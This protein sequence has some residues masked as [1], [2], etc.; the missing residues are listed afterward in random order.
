MTDEPETELAVARAAWT[1]LIDILAEQLAIAPEASREH[2]VGALVA[3]AGYRM[4]NFTSDPSSQFQQARLDL[5][6]RVV[7]RL[8]ALDAAPD[9]R[10]GAGEPAAGRE[11][12]KLNIR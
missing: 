4:T 5:V 12:L 10:G 8:A 7:S 2:I 6:N 9:V 1:Q 11:T 3:R